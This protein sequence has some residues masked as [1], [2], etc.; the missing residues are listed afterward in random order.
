MSFQA[1]LDNIELKTGKTPNEFIA[2]A[3]ERGFDVGVGKFS[4]MAS[5]KARILGKAQGFVKIVRDR[6]Y[7]EILGLKGT[8]YATVSACPVGY[9]ADDDKYASAPKVRFAAKELIDRR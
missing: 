4:F 8:G 6:K 3:K 9:R 2:L 7:D 5:G 1:Y